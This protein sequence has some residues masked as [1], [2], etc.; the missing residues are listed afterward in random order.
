MRL[1]RRLLVV[2]LGLGIA[3]TLAGAGTYA[4]FVSSTTNP[5]NGYQ[6]GTVD[7]SDNDGG[8]A[9]LSVSGIRPSD[10]AVTGCI[11]VTYSGSLPASAKLYGA[12]SGA[13]APYL[14]VI[15]TEGTSSSP[16]NSCATFA[17]ASTLYNGTLA[18]LPAGWASGLADAD[19]T[20]TTGEVHAYRFEV[21]VQ[22][23]SLAQGLSGSATFTW[24]ARNQ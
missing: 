21:T 24:E 22:N 3:G 23:T 8:S 6:A 13:L 18:A 4:A 17:G 2:A 15:I 7:V 12:S 20:W 1:V 11:R 9:V 5:G 14:N 10:P 19:G 16:F